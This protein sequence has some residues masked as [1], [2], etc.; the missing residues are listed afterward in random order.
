MWNSTA[1]TMSMVRPCTAKFTSPSWKSWFRFSMSLV[2]LVMIT[3][4]FSSVKKSSDRRWRWAK[5]LTRRS[6]S[7]PW[8]IRPVHATRA[9]LATAVTATATM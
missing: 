3:P 5:I 1:V 9:P 2:I 7:R 4:A 6:T 8:P